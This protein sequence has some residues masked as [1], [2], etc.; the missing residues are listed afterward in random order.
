M[1]ERRRAGTRAGWLVALSL[2]LLALWLA[3]LPRSSDEAP[4]PADADEPGSD[5]QADPPRAA[6]SPRRP[7]TDVATPVAPGS[8][9]PRERKGCHEGDS[10]WLDAH[11]TPIELARACEGRGC[12]AGECKRPSQTSAI[13]CGEV[14]AY[15]LCEGDTALMCEGNEVRRF[16]CKA[17]GERCVMTREGARCLPR[18]GASDCT[19]DDR[20]RCQGDVLRQCVEGTFQ[21]TDCRLRHARCE[22]RDGE[23]GCHVPE[24]I[25]ALLP[26]SIDASSEAEVCNGRDDDHDRRIDEDGACARVSLVAFVPQGAK[27][28]EL[29]RRMREELEIVNRVYRPMTFEWKRTVTVER[30][31]ASFDPAQI[32]RVARELSQRE[33][34]FYKDK[35]RAVSPAQA[36]AEEQGLSFYI[37]VLYT[38]SIVGRPPKSG[39]AT[40]PNSRCGGVRLRDDPSPVSGLVVVGE[41]RTQQTLAHELGHYLGLCHTHEE[42]ERFAWGAPLELACHAEG[43]GICDTPRDPGP[44]ACVPLPMCVIECEGDASWRQSS[45]REPSPDA[46]NIMSYYLPCRQMLSEEQVAEAMQN[47]ALRRGWFRCQNLGYCA[48]QPGAVNDCPLEMTCVPLSREA[49]GYTCALYGP[50]LPGAPCLDPL[51][52]GQGALCMRL[53]G[54]GGPRC[55]RPCQED[56]EACQCEDLGLPYR[57]CREDLGT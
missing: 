8:A 34:S 19:P 42:V 6:E 48:C 33:S 38:E 13:G 22:V 28:E 35:L 10:Y 18:G 4:T 56:G 43:D 51:H 53:E 17:Y 32:D 46:S 45:Q 20:A 12:E 2:V 24:A 15:G 27:L 37:P 39:L 36:M 30:S 47:L 26:P 57:V 23:P 7:K 14:S 9:T 40:L 44:P 29:E 5:V 21:M 41:T 55:V 52:C 16:D 3:V 50:A 49:G 31:L 1:R 54:A 11:G 25:R